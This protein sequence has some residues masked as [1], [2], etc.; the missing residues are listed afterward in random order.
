[1]K[2]AFILFIIIVCSLDLFAQETASF[3]FLGIPIDGPRA[4]FIAALKQ[5]GFSLDS[6]T[7]ELRGV[8]NG[9]DSYI[10][11]HEN[12]GKVDRVMVLDANGISESQI[13]IRFNQLL[14]QFK[15]KN[16][17]YLDLTL[18]ESDNTPI[19]EGER[20]G[21]EIAVNKK[22]YTAS[23]FFNP[24]FNWSESQRDSLYHSISMNISEEYPDGKPEYMGREQWEDFVLM[25][26]FDRIAKMA[27]GNV[28]FTIYHASTKYYLILYYDNT[29][30]RAAGEDL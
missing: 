15:A 22:N 19:P 5:K 10:I 6:S 26:T 18:S 14:Q 24:C 21:Y 17:K 28:W 4:E 2:R 27:Y 7:G 8:F 9:V 1:M 20:I 12:K 16:D 3:C 29:K 25:R 13:K 30:N 23:F 11:V